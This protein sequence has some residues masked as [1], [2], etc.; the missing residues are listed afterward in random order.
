MS[1]LRQLATREACDVSDLSLSIV[2][3]G[4]EPKANSHMAE[5]GMF[6]SFASMIIRSALFVI[7]LDTILALA[8]MSRYVCL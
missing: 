2:G 5:T 3:K 8:F 6:C 1:C 4:K 7:I